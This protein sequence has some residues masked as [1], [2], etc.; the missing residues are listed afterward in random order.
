[1][2]RTLDALIEALTDL[3]DHLAPRALAE[4]APPGWTGVGT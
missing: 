3:D 2:T 1:M 4:V